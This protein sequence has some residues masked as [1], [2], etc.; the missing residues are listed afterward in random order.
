M[1]IA[2]GFGAA[3]RVHASINTT[4]QPEQ[5]LIGTLPREEAACE[6]REIQQPM[7]NL[8]DDARSVLSAGD[9]GGKRGWIK[10]PP[11]SL[12]TTAADRRA[13]CRT[14]SRKSRTVRTMR[15]ITPDIRRPVGLPADPLQRV[16]HWGGHGLRCQPPLTRIGEAA[17]CIFPAVTVRRAPDN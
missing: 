2:L 5:T 9:I 8:I 6:L 4:P 10:S 12:A 16:A 3:Q 15:R 14:S 11:R 1:Q 17:R 13:P 7:L